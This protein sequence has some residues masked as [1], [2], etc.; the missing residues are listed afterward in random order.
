[1]YCGKL[2][3]YSIKAFTVKTTGLKFDPK[4]VIFDPTSLVNYAP[5]K[6]G[7]IFD[8]TSLVNYASIKKGS[9]LTPVL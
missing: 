6:K 3:Q 2:I 9:I 7:V 4:R 1:M 8:P 5:T